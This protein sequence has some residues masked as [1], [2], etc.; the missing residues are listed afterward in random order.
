MS[1]CIKHNMA[2]MATVENKQCSI[3]KKFIKHKWFSLVLTWKTT[4]TPYCNLDLHIGDP[5]TRVLRRVAMPHRMRWRH[6]LIRRW[7]WI[8]NTM[9]PQHRSE[10]SWEKSP[11]TSW[12][13]LRADSSY[14]RWLSLHSYGTFSSKLYIILWSELPLSGHILP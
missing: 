7:I 5:M 10:W 8:T 3:S 13:S 14:L 1:H 11:D 9:E 6:A 2:N 12:P 4:L